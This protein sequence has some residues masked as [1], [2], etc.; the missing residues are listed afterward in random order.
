MTRLPDL[1]HRRTVADIIQEIRAPR[2]GPDTAWYKV[3]PSEAHGINFSTGWLNSTLAT[4]AP[5][6]WHSADDGQVRL[7]GRVKGGDDGTV[8]FTLPP[9]ARPEFDCFF[10]VSTEDEN[11]FALDSIMFRAWELGDA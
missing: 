1:P 4:G 7:R 3:G 2:P 5:A 10:V 8:V 11:E 9:E 6:S